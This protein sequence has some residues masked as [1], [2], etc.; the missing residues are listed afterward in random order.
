MDVPYARLCLPW[1]GAVALTYGEVGLGDFT[2]ERL[3]DPTILALAQRIVVI[4][5]GS[6]NPAAFTPLRAIA[7][8]AVG[9]TVEV[10]IDAM[11]GA[12]NNPLSLEQHNAKARRCLAFGGL[13]AV[14]AGLIRAIAALE[15][16]TDVAQALNMEAPAMRTPML[17]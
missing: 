6:P 5:D 15:Q 12:P 8:T 17:D 13:E 16:A 4:D 1:L 14:H 9:E 3:S 11:L 2:P 10:Q 7:R